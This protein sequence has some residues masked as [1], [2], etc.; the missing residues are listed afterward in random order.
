MT[1]KMMMLMVLM[2]MTVMV[3]VFEVHLNT[4]H[5]SAVPQ[6]ALLVFQVNLEYFIE[7]VLVIVIKIP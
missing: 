6:G 7:I 5:A 4:G 3:M 1:T 2:M